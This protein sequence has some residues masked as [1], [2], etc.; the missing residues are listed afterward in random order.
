MNPTDF[1]VLI[2][3]KS[4]VPGQVK[5]RLTPPLTPEQAADLAAAA[6]LDTVDAAVEA[7]GG[8]RH[9][10]MVSMAGSPRDARLATLEADLNGCLVVQQRGADFGTRLQNAHEDAA[11][12]HPGRPVVQIGMDTPQVHA[13]D[14]RAAAAHLLDGSDAVLGPA[15]DGGW[16]LLGLTHPDAAAVL[17]TV[18]M[19]TAQTG[20]LTHESLERLGLRIAKMDPVVDVDT[21]ADAVRV[22]AMCTDSRFGRS[23][24]GFSAR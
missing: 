22:A 15:E 12:A 14:L 19:S 20:R 7:V 21:Y 11:R 6:L 17:P 16:W 4:P 10:V 3:A 13:D 18:P 23:L 9:Q 5:T 2:T 8:C 1:V 24:A